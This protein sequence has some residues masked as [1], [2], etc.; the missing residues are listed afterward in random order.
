MKKNIVFI[1][2]FYEKI[3]AFGKIV[4][5]FSVSFYLHRDA[6]TSSDNKLCIFIKFISIILVNI[7]VKITQIFPILT[8]NNNSIF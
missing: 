2:V 3:Y 5:T 8:S 6:N 7:G 1:S 4:N